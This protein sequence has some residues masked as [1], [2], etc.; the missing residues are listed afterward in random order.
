MFLPDP[1]KLRIVPQQIREFRPLLDQLRAGQSV[2]FFLEATDAEHLTQHH[3]RIVEAQRLIE[4]AGH[5][6]FVFLH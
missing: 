3:A 4:V 2:H 5:E 1:A 6:V